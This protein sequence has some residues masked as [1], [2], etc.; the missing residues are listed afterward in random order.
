M[1]KVHI[2]ALGLLHEKPRHGYELQQVVKE[3]QLNH[4]ANVNPGSVY[5]ALQ[6]LEAKGF[7]SGREET[8]GNNPPRTVYSITDAGKQELRRLVLHYLTKPNHPGDFWIGSAFM[9][10][11]VSKTE[12]LKLVDKMIAGIQKHRANEIV[13]RHQHIA[14]YE[15]IPFNWIKL[16]ELGEAMTKTMLDQMQEL[17]EV[18]EACDIGKYFLRDDEKLGGI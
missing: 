4:W 5:K 16:M 2:T 7:I 11:V 15:D 1:S 9:L 18:A 10:G 8:D 17:R 3:R 12:Y 14:M 13:E 6:T